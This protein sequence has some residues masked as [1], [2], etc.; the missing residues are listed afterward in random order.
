VG[1]TSL[2]LIEKQ[3]VAKSKLF[4]I[5]ELH[6]AIISKTSPWRFVPP[7]PVFPM[8]ILVTA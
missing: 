4:I 8:F 5:I 6:F 1:G 7:T 2:Y 3:C